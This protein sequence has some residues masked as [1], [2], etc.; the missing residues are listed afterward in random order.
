MKVLFF[1]TESTDLVAPWG[2]ILCA[3]FGGVEGPIETFRADAKRFKGRN[4]V[5]DSKLCVAIRDKL[6]SADMIVG[7]NSILHDIALLNGRL[8]LA[9]ERPC[10][11]GDIHGTRH[12]DLM[13][14]AGGQS[15]KLGGKSLKN[16]S[17][18]FGVA[19]SKTDLDGEAW[20]LAGAGDKKAMDQVVEHCVADVEVTRELWPH[21]APHVKKFQF[22]L[23]EV[24]PWIEKIPSRRAAA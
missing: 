10:R 1:D 16:V 24:W 3:S 14:Y 8:G 5:D 2:R 9:K 19:H 6:E 13:W 12:L 18:F 23:S 21:L 4:V 22:S 20:Q 11:L 7:W 17:K 15:M